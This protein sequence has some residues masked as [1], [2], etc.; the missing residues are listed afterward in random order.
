MFFALAGV[1]ISFHALHGEQGLYAMMKEKYKLQRL[2]ED[3][4]TITAKRKKLE[5]RVALLRN[6]S[7]D[8]DMLDEQSRRFLGYA[9]EDEIMLLK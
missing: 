5:V 8:R 9:E 4:I 1:W 6:G 3:K 7:I 2:Q